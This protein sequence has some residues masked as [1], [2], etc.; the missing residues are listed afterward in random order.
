MGYVYG[1][2]VCQTIS[3]HASEGEAE[4][5]R[6]GHHLKVH[7]GRA[8][9]DEWISDTTPPSPPPGLPAPPS[10]LSIARWL[11]GTWP[12]RAVALLLVVVVVRLALVVADL[13]PLFAPVPPAASPAPAWTNPFASE[14]PT[15]SPWTNPFASEAPTVSP[16]PR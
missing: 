7:H 13:P 9:L 8:P 6:A 15:A 1:C 3:R 5:E 10:P 14:A 11:L 16:S 4:A 2:G 12:G